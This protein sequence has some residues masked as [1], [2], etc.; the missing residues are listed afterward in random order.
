[1]A[2]CGTLFQ[3]AS[4][5]RQL[6]VS[7]SDADQHRDGRTARLAFQQ[8]RHH[9]PAGPERWHGV[10]TSCDT[11]QDVMWRTSSTPTTTWTTACRAC[12]PSA[13]PSVVRH[14][15][16]R[17]SSASKNSTHPTNTSATTSSSSAS[18]SPIDR[19]R[20][21]TTGQATALTSGHVTLTSEQST[22][23]KQN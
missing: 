2:Q 7:V 16:C 10:K 18:I 4:S 3:C 13:P 9:Q 21:L 1:M 8:A 23:H 12:R 6:H 11:R 19:R 17:S 5:S 22:I 15:A 20:P 14:S